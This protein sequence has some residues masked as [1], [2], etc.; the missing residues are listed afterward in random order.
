MEME[1]HG[2]EQEP[3][4]CLPIIKQRVTWFCNEL[5]LSLHFLIFLLA[6]FVLCCIVLFLCV[7][8][9]DAISQQQNLQMKIHSML[10]MSLY[11][12]LKCF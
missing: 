7:C 1:K 9:K 2:K 10:Q 5:L 4:V 12:F 3:H 6:Y 11:P 8:F